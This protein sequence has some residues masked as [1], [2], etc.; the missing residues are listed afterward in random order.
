MKKSNKTGV[1]K[2]DQDLFQHHMKN[3]TPLA[4]SNKISAE[5]M[6]HVKKTTHNHIRQTIPT[7]DNPTFSFRDTPDDEPNDEVSAHSALFFQR[8]G[9]QHALMKRLKKGLISRKLTIDLHGLNAN[10]AN[11]ELFNFLETYAA[12]TQI[13]VCIIHGKGTRSHQGK[14]VLKQ[15]INKWLKQHPRVIAFCSA[16]PQDGGTGA[17]Y[18]LLKRNN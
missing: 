14:P 8:D 17:T 4:P 18:V 12:T 6:Q 3:V 11:T 9:V 7:A 10:Q 15:K 2:K 13:C 16:L 1:S 5:T